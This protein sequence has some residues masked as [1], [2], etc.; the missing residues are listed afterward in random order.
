MSAGASRWLGRALLAGS[1]VLSAVGQR[2]M[3][4]GMQELHA[5]ATRGVVLSSASWSEL[6]PT[7]LQALRV[8]EADR[9]GLRGGFDGHQRP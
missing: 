9:I 6:A 3:K 1:I 4:A 7:S 5:L 2:G 8:I